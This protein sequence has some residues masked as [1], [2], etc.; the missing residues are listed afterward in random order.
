VGEE[1]LHQG[2]LALA[3]Q[4]GLAPPSLDGILNGAQGMGDDP[5]FRERWQKKSYILHSKG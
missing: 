3:F 1:V 4:G 2:I 5:L